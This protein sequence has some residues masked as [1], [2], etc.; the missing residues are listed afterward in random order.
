M[1][2]R[3]LD[4]YFRNLR[5]NLLCA[6]KEKKRILSD[7][8]IN[9]ENWMEAHPEGDEK[10]FLEAFGTPEDIAASYMEEMG[11]TDVSKK[12][13]LRKRFSKTAFLLAAVAMI[14]L[15]VFAIQIAINSLSLV[16]IS[17]NSSYHSLIN[18]FHSSVLKYSSALSISFPSISKSINKSSNSSQSYKES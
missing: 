6:N 4:R 7:L 18:S 9:A 13:L 1:N 16:N 14:A 3:I 11:Y 2:K 17:L 5:K 15:I 10:A 8:R 12:I